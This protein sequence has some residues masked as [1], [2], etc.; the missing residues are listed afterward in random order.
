[1]S[2]ASFESEKN[3][4][5]DNQSDPKEQGPQNADSESQS[6]ASENSLD[7]THM[8]EIDINENKEVEN[9]SHTVNDDD[10]ADEDDNE[11]YQV[12]TKTSKVLKDVK[13]NTVYENTSSVTS[14]TTEAHVKVT[15]MICLELLAWLI[16]DLLHTC[17]CDLRHE[18]LTKEIVF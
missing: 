18:I 12:K 1:M 2:E 7:E 10:D 3:A 9:H 15:V 4:S 5:Q 14:V 17:C 8:T 6:E 11:D 16:V 13:E